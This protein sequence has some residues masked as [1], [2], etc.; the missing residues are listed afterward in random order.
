[1]DWFLISVAGLLGLA[2]G[3]FINVCLDRLPA[4]LSL[5]SPAS[6]CP[7]C[8]IL[9]RPLELVPVFSYLMLRGRCRHCST[10]IPLRVLLVE[11]TTGGIFAALWLWYGLSDRILSPLKAFLLAVGLSP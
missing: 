9:L 4:R 11:L 3:S 7:G 5:F 1:M 10:G 2:V 8:N 6:Q